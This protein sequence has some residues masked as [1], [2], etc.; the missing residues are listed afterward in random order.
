MSNVKNVNVSMDSNILSWIINEFLFLLSSLCFL[1]WSLLIFPIFLCFYIIYH[2]LK[3][4]LGTTF[5]CISL[6]LGMQ[7][8]MCGFPLYLQ[9]KRHSWDWQNIDL[10]I[11]GLSNYFRNVMK[12]RGTK[13]LKSKTRFGHTFLWGCATAAHQIEGNCTSSNW[14][15]WEKKEGTYIIYLYKIV[16]L[17]IYIYLYMSN[18]LYL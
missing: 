6:P 16:Y 3:S 18:F 11:G 2:T 7:S 1:I 5:L 9:N 12:K 15:D 17:Y 4:I 8:F 14:S 10:T 13:H